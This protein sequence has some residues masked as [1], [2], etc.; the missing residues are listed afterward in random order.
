MGVEAGQELAAIV[1]RKEWERQL[2]GGLFYWGIGQSLGRNAEVAAN[3]VST[4]HAVFSPM[5]SKPKAIDVNP[6]EVVMWTAWVDHYG[7]PHPLPSHSLVTS[8]ASLPSGKRKES[9]YALV[10]TSEQALDSSPVG[11]V[12]PD[13]LRNVTTDKPLGASQ[14]TAVVRVAASAR[15]LNDAKSYPVSFTAELQ[16]PYFVRLVQP[17]LLDAIDLEEI[18]QVSV[19]GD[20]ESWAHLVNRLRS[21]IGL[22]YSPGPTLDFPRVARAGNSL[23]CNPEKSTLHFVKAPRLLGV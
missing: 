13:H 15:V 4:L 16:F 19:L 14:V 23:D 22:E 7:R 3:D 5:I 11:R 17:V 10:C 9:H 18:S 6:S 21:R 2:G 8:R 20:S 1:R 12:F